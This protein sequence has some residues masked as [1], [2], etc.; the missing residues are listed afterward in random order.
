MAGKK[1][2]ADQFEKDKEL[3]AMR[4]FFTKVKYELIKR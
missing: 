2:P 1:F 4:E 3:A